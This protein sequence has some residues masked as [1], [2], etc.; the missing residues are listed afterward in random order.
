MKKIFL[1]LTLFSLSVSAQQFQGMK[2]EN[3]DEIKKIME[4]MQKMQACMAKINKNE[5]KTIQ[6]NAEK[7]ARETQALCKKG[8]RKQAQQ[9][10][11]DAF[12][13][14]KNDPFAI[15]LRKC[16]NILESMSSED[17]ITETHI[18]DSPVDNFNGS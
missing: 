16:T 8:K 5:L 3:E 11:A 18:C 13:K 15:K 7:L 1:I 4:S 6:Q 9:K 10:A 17:E 14:F 12:N 2:M